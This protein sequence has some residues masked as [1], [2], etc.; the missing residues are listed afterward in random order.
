MSGGSPALGDGL[1]QGVNE[2]SVEFDARIFLTE[3]GNGF[4][5]IHDIHLGAKLPVA[6]RPDASPILDSLDGAVEKL[7]QIGDRR[8]AQRNVGGFHC[9]IL[10]S[11]L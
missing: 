4:G 10:C 9:D 1:H 8:P 2:V 6:V 5:D 3:E 7:G 11:L